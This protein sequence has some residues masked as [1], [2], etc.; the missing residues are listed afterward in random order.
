MGLSTQL[1]VGWIN[2]SIVLREEAN[3]G[4]NTPKRRITFP[5][6]HLFSLYRIYFMKIEKFT[7][8]WLNCLPTDDLKMSLK[9]EWRRKTRI[10]GVDV[11][12]I[13][14]KDTQQPALSV[15]PGSSSLLHLWRELGFRRLNI[16]SGAPGTSW[17]TLQEF[18]SWFLSI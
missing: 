9:R 16:A 7:F 3:R 18:I 4:K 5:Y 2:L 14:F 13:P 12:I 15:T 6:A 11:W 10:T 8:S 17:E 1:V